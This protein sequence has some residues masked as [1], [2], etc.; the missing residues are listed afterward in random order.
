[1]K[2]TM[3]QQAINLF[4]LFAISTSSLAEGVPSA[5][6]RLPAIYHVWGASTE[7]KPSI[8]IEE[9]EKCMG[10]DSKIRQSDERFKVETKSMNDE[11]LVAESL[12]KDHEAARLTLDNEAATIQ[13]EK[14]QMNSR[15]EAFEKKKTE[16]S[17]LTSK[18]M[19]AAT[20][21]KIN[22]QIEQLNQDI[23]QQNARALA[24]NGRILQFQ[25]KQKSFND[26]LE[27]LKVKLE[28]VNENTKQF[29]E[30][31]KAFSDSLIAFR[32]QCEGERRLEK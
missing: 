30:R 3:T 4:M 29:N 17:A 9:I 20:A 22:A 10:Q 25:Q 14:E 1:M 18:K 6:V 23:K 5:S 15:F 7:G 19:D 2:V 28:K 13:T 8:T 26:D 32:A 24:L 16:F 11:I 12:V 27:V 21:K 31:Q